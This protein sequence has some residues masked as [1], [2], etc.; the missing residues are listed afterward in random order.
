MLKIAETAVVFAEVPDEVTLALNI[1][2]CPCHC[3]DCH[4]K[5]L[6]KSIGIPLTYGVIDELIKRNRGITC[7]AF[8]GGDSDPKEVNKLAYLI[9]T[10]SDYPYKIAWYSG[11]NELS[12]EIDL[13]IFDYIKLGPYIKEN[14]PLDN[15]N[16]NQRFYSV[17]ESWN[18]SKNPTY[19]LV[20]NTHLFWKTELCQN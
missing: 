12:T 10:R 15:P 11:M 8:M 19:K 18:D 13:S 5:H 17:E 9:K 2:E 4:S 3:K 6:W 20:D 16:T 7:I 14:G 1:S